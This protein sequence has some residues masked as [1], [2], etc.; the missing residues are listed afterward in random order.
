MKQIIRIIAGQYKGRKLHFPAVQGLRPTPDRVRET[1]FNWLMHD[2]AGA[3]CL[4]AFAGSGALGFEAFSRGAF[5]VVLVE[6]AAQAAATLKKNIHTLGAERIQLVKTNALAYMQKTTQEFDII[7]LDPPFGKGY[8]AQ[9]LAVIEHSTL[10]SQGGLLYM[11]SEQTIPMNACHWQQI[12]LK[13]AG[14]VVY[15]LYKKIDKTTVL[16]QS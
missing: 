3:R 15:A 7:F 4:D 12:R 6:Q 10:L 5:E 11:E 2:I 16:Q 9:C 13:K 14:Q 8:L 1:L